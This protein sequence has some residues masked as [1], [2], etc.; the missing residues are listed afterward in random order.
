MAL[1]PITNH[2][3]EGLMALIPPFWGKPRIAAWLQTYLDQ[4]QDLEDAAW[5]VLNAYDIDTCDMPRLNVLAK[6]VGQPNL[7]WSLET[8]RSVVRGKIAANRSRGR[9]DDLLNV[10]RLSI[11]AQYGAT[12][13]TLTPAT[14][15]VEI[16]LAV[17][18]TYR[19]ALEFLLPKTRAAGV[20][21][22]V[23]YPPLPDGVPGGGA[24][25]RLDSAVA[26][27]QTS[28]LGS[29]V[30]GNGAHTYSVRVL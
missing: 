13:V 8:F 16:S 1:A 15:F 4:V 3:N 21:M 17:L 14:L 24:R 7:G 2:F 28:G 25:F 23:L 30:S 29:S 18:A 19:T 22:Q 26:G 9:E 6:I 20:H 11:G 5:E 27:T 10:L 12:F